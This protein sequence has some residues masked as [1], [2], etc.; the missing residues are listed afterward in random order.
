MTFRP[1]EVAAFRQVFLESKD[2]IRGMPGCLHVE[3]LQDVKAPHIFFTYSKWESEAAL[4]DYRHSALF[5]ATWAR[6]KILFGD[7]PEAWSTGLVAVGG[8]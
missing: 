5:E 4:N 6:T 1:E 3:C 8:Q 7:K 2:L